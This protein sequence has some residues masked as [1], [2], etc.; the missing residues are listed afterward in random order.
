MEKDVIKLIDY[1]KDLLDF[2]NPWSNNFDDYR[3]IHDEALMMLNDNLPRLLEYC[4][5][6]YQQG[7]KI[8]PELDDLRAILGQVIAKGRYSV[9]AFADTTREIEEDIQS[10]SYLWKIAD[11]GKKWQYWLNKYYHTCQHGEQAPA[12]QEPSQTTKVLSKEIPAELNTGRARA[13]FAKSVE[14]GLM[15]EQYEWQKTYGLYGYFVDKVSDAL[16]IKDNADRI[17]WAM[18]GKIIPNHSKMLNTAKQT[19]NNYKNKRLPPPQGD[20][21]VERIIKETR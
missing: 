7:N 13:I 6:D 20:D 17:K 4:K 11:E 16:G 21:I 14:A 1:L 15:T 18:F 10:R 5:R 2:P 19:I 8:P 9:N 12:N 3:E